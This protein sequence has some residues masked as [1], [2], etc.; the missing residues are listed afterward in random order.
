MFNPLADQFEAM[1]GGIDLNDDI[2]D[3]EIR[4]KLYSGLNW[5]LWSEIDHIRAA[6]AAELREDA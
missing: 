3:R 4:Q 2:I 5:G 6:I 1:R